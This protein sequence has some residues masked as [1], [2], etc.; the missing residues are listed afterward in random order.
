MTPWRVLRLLPPVAVGIA[1]AA[2]LLSTAEPPV[3]KAQAERSVAARTVIAEAAPVRPVVRGYGNV[4]PARSWEAVAEVAG[5]ITWRLGRLETGNMIKAGTKVLQID[6]ATYELAV[7]QTEADLAAQRAEAEQL[8]REERNTRRI[9]SLE[10]ERLALAESDLERAR[11]LVEQGTAPQTR[12]DEQERATLQVRRG[13]TELRNTLDLIPS[14]RK[15]LEAQ[16][17]RTEAA[18]SRAR[19]DLEKTRVTTP[20]DLRVGKV[21]VERHQF[22]GTG[23]PLVS[24]D[25]VARAEITAHLPIET[26]PR[27]VGAAGA[28][29]GNG[30]MQAEALQ[31]ALSRIEAR[32][33]LVADRDQVWQ[34]R[35]LRVEN[36]LD[37]QARS[38]PVVVAV[39]GPYAGTNPPE[40]LPLVPN[41]Y[42]EITLTGPAGEPRVSLPDSAVH[43]DDTVYLRDDDGRLEL[44]KVEVDWRQSGR[45]ILSRGIEPGEAVI[46]DDLVP[47][48]PGMKVV[49]A[50]GASE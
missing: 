47:A 42:V 48:I 34:G 23:Q 8:D 19:R 36:A 18:L 27:L 5:A 33:R 22:A 25:G 49:P 21:H 43:Q 17:A 4:R 26:F 20:F 31:E 2:W 37:P 32:V 39:D 45:A 41:M 44:R 15:R 28:A 16:I 10:Q 24:G 11:N 12:L 40:R 35:V 13:V 46:L 50:D 29:G 9:L 1:V 3:R 6:P 38:V 7:A 14:R 30:P